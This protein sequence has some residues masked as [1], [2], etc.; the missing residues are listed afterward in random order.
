MEQLPQYVDVREILQGVVR[1]FGLQQKG[2]AQGFGISVIQSHILYEL[3]KRPN[4]SLNELAD[5]LCV[6]ASTLSRQVQQLVELDLLS[7]EPDQKDRRYVTL[8]LT[9]KGH[10][11]QKAVAEAMEDYILS[12]FQYVPADKKRQVLESLQL[13]NEAMGQ[14]SHCCLPPL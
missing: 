12:I 11:Q 4:L 10:E 9:A 6:E 5:V 13:L 14:S 7:R 1:R 8:T 2:G 3:H